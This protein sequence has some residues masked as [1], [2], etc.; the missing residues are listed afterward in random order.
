MSGVSTGKGGKVKIDDVAVAEIQSWDFKETME[1]KQ[2]WS[3]G[4]PHMSAL[5]TVSSASGS[6]EMLRDEGNEGQ[7]DL[8]LGA[9]VQL[10]LYP[11]GDAAGAKYIDALALITEIGRPV[12]K[13]DEIVISA[14]WISA[15]AWT[16][17]TV[18]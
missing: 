10:S 5:A 9:T 11:D 15:G 6:F 2:Y 1:N 17:E 14:S 12:S 4:D 7:G 18:A 13:G 8:V 16:T 3:M